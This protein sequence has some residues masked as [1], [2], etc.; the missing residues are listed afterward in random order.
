MTNQKRRDEP[1]GESG[2]RG[3]L[4]TRDDSL[5][6]IWVA[7]VIVIFLMLFLLN[8]A[9]LPSSLFPSPTPLPS[10]SAAPSGSPS[11]SGSGS[12]SPSGSVAATPTATVAPSP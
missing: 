4:P 11:T 3:A 8:F 6:R 10:V 2:Y 12:A 9:G 7:A 5:A 1:S